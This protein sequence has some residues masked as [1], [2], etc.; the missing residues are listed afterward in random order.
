MKEN[1]AYGPK[2]AKDAVLAMII[3]DGISDRSHR[4]NILSEKLKFMGPC[5]GDH[6]KY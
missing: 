5:H 3:D 1:I 6:V 4:K 2:D